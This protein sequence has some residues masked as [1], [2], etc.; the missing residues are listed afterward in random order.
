MKYPKFGTWKDYPLNLV[1][2]DICSSLHTTHSTNLLRINVVYFPKSVKILCRYIQNDAQR[3][4]NPKSI[5]NAA[6]RRATFSGV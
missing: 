2:L 3:V 5:G 4:R 6:S 1:L